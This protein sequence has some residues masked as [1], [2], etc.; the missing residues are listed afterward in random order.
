MNVALDAVRNPSATVAARIVGAAVVVVHRMARRTVQPPAAAGLL[1]LESRARAL[2]WI[3]RELR[4]VEQVVISL[5]EHKP[6][7]LADSVP[8]CRSGQVREDCLTNANGLAG[9]IRD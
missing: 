4:P 2:G 6:V 3:A 9:T 8:D 5:R 1:Q 7:G